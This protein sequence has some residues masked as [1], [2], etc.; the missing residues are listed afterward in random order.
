MLVLKPV[1]SLPDTEYKQMVPDPFQQ[2]LADAEAFSCPKS[3][4]YFFF[5]IFAGFLP[6]GYIGHRVLCNGETHKIEVQHLTTLHRSPDQSMIREIANILTYLPSFF[7]HL[8]FD[9]IN[10]NMFECNNLFPGIV[11]HL[12]VNGWVSNSTSV[13]CSFDPFLSV[14]Y[15]YSQLL[16]IGRI[17]H[18]LVDREGLNFIC[19]E[20]LTPQ[21]ILSLQ[22]TVS[23]SWA[24]PFHPYLL[25]SHHSRYSVAVFRGDTAISWFIADTLNSKSL[26][27]ETVWFDP[28]AVS[29]A[30]SYAMFYKSF[31]R[32]FPFLASPEQYEFKFSYLTTNKTMPKL[33]QWLRPMLRLETSYLSYSLSL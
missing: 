14:H 10:L 18:Y 23:P 9:A 17:F 7:S 5:I 22:E 19:F 16:R 33:H 12:E 32:F 21:Q 29:V 25:S 20:Q 4:D 28:S 13:Y 8:H 3:S 2:F 11:L 6:C 15:W 1:H 31:I 26:A 30:V 27:I 24:A